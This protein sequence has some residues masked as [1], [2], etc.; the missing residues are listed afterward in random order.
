MNKRTP[1]S[2]RGKE[3]DMKKTQTDARPRTALVTGASSGMGREFCRRLAAEGECDELWLVARR[4]EPMERLAEELGLPCR[5]IAADL[6]TEEGLAALKA[7]LAEGTPRL[8]WVV[9]AAGF[10]VFGRFD[11][12]SDE[13]VFKMIDLNVKGAVAVTRMAIPYIGRGGHIVELGSGSVFCPLPNF[14]IYASSKVFILHFSR[15][16][17]EELKHLGVSCTVFCPGWVDTGFFSVADKE[18]DEVH[19]PPLKKR[20]PLLR[21]DRVVRGAVRAARRGRALYTTNW[22]TKAEH[23]LS[24]LLPAS[25]MIAMWKSMQNKK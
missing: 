5:V 22:F 7:A 15:A 13:D 1:A 17:R 19:K 6:A 10:G 24:K 8:S 12:V 14:N 20:K 11:E 18:G 9:P 2:T 21:A 23:L 3:Q 4:R 25:W 16:L